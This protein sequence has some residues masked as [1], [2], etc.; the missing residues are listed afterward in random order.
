MDE[1]NVESD[2]AGQILA[3]VVIQ[4]MAMARLDGM[5]AKLVH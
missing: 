1:G 5:A 2:C 4:Q 3:H